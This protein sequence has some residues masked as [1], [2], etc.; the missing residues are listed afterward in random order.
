MWSGSFDMFSYLY[1]LI[2]QNIDPKGNS[3]KINHGMFA[4][5]YKDRSTKIYVKILKNLCEY[6]RSIKTA[7][8]RV[9]NILI[10]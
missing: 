3:I 6:V 1:T 5:I 4:S 2:L 7:N 10:S 8:Y 9:N